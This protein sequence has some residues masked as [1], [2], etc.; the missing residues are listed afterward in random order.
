MCKD[1]TQATYS[2]SGPSFDQRITGR[3]LREFAALV[4]FE[5]EH[6]AAKLLDVVDLHDFYEVREHMRLQAEP[7]SGSGSS[8]AGPLNMVLPLS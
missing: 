1:G 7:R 6:K 5:L 8:T 2:S 3:S 4:G